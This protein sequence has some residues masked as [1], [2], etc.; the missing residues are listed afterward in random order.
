MDKLRQSWEGLGKPRIVAA[1]SSCLAA[2]REALPDG[3]CVEMEGAA[4]AQ[5]CH[6]YGLPFA[7]MRSISDRADDSAHVDFNRFIAEVASVYTREILGTWLSG[8]V[9]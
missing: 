1:C 3:L 7:A 9:D 5:V 6:D 4:V 2:L 8:R